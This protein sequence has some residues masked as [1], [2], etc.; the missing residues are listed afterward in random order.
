MGG[1]THRERGSSG[2]TERGARKR[3]LIA[4][5]WMYAA[6]IDVSSF[7]CLVIHCLL[8]QYTHHTEAATA[9]LPE[10]RERGGEEGGGRAGERSKREEKNAGGSHFK[11][12]KRVAVCVCLRKG[13]GC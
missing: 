11:P 1:G 6:V 8:S 7:F 3:T 10:G 13:G 5:P 9:T 12:A 4:S 2:G